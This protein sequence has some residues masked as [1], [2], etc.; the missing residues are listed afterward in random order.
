MKGITAPHFVGTVSGDTFGA[1]LTALRNHVGLSREQFADETGL[2]KEQVRRFETK[3]QLATKNEF[4]SCDAVARRY[5]VQPAW[6]YAGSMIPP[7]MWP[8][9]WQHV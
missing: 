8:D 1:R 7:S 6:L 5:G 4:P 2:D 9:W 3:G